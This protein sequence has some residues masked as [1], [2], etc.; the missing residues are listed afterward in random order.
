MSSASIGALGSRVVADV[1]PEAVTAQTARFTYSLPVSHPP[2]PPNATY[3]Q[4][5]EKLCKEFP[6]FSKIHAGVDDW[7]QKPVTKMGQDIF[8][9]IVDGLKGLFTGK[10]IN[11]GKPILVPGGHTFTLLEGL[12]ENAVQGGKKNIVGEWNRL[13]NLPKLQQQGM[14]LFESAC[15]F[16]KAAFTRIGLMLRYRL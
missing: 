7:M 13:A 14:A 3:G 6:N 2:L 9:G 16:G 1:L 5:W 11:A 10:N 15:I 4:M 8:G 12:G